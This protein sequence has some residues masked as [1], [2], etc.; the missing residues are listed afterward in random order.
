M[1]INPRTTLDKR[2]L[3][4]LSHYL[5]SRKQEAERRLALLG[6]KAVVVLLNCVEEETYIHR[7]SRI[8]SV[9]MGLFLMIGVG[10]FVVVVVLLLGALTR[11]DGYFDVGTVPSDAWGVINENYFKKRPFSTAHRNA[12]LALAD[13]D[14]VR[15]L[16]IFL[17]VFLTRNTGIEND[18]FSAII[19]ICD[20]VS[21]SDA[22]LIKPDTRALMRHVLS[23]PASVFTCSVLRVLGE[24]GDEADVPTLKHLAQLPTTT[25]GNTAV[26]GTAEKALEA[27]QRRLQRKQEAQT[28]LRASGLSDPAEMLLRPQ[29]SSPK[30]PENQLLRPSEN[31]TSHE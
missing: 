15:A 31:A 26:R 27:V 9:I 30:E 14:D 21:E 2:T 5:P 4:D 24:V 29:N 28:L 16:P 13:Y 10:V 19:R 11:G 17:K 22:P 8:I 6:P 3:E 20:R 7:R 1:L 12:I 25:E 23:N 18:C